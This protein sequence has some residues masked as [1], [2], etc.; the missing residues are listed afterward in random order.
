MAAMNLPTVLVIATS[1][2][3]S[4]G[5]TGDPLLQ[6]VG[7]RTLLERHVRTLA[8]LGCEWFVVVAPADAR[9]TLEQLRDELR[10]RLRFVLEPKRPAT[11]ARAF[12]AA[13]PALAHL[14][15]GPVLV[16]QPHYV[17]DDGLYAELV[18]AWSG[19]DSGV[20][21]IV[22]TV[23]PG[24]VRRDD[25]LLTVNGER[26]TGC[27]AGPDGGSPSMRQYVG[28]L[29]CSWSRELCETIG[30][31]ADRGSP[32]DAVAKGISRL[33]VWNEFRNLPY[34]GPWLRL[35]ASSDLDLIKNGAWRALPS[36][37]P[38]ISQDNQTPAAAPRSGSQT[39]VQRPSSWR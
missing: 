4:F 5:P 22:A 13:E 26:L 34:A 28:A 14:A 2:E 25:L 15:T 21:G 12:V 8:A 36:P 31:E 9:S 37:R 6:P 7:D 16:T 29:A 3:N 18:R 30:E 23:P 11:L 32:G 1:P 35:R 38:V 17:V 20:E 33:I 10:L 39:R 27:S 24:D 19:R